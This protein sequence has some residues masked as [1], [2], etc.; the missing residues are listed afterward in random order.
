[1][2][3]IMAV[4]GETA[5][6]GECEQAEEGQARQTDWYAKRV[7]Q[8]SAIEPGGAGRA[9]GHRQRQSG[10]APAQHSKRHRGWHTG[11]LPV[12]EDTGGS[13]AAQGMHAGRRG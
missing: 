3:C 4:P 11:D 10:Q 12:V 5:G 2:L 8:L 7:M 1:M 9:H 6:E 13:R